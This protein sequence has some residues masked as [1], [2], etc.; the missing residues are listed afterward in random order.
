MDIENENLIDLGRKVGLDDETLQH[1]IQMNSAIEQI[2]NQMF[3][4][5][6]QRNFDISHDVLLNEIVKTGVD[7]EYARQFMLDVYN[8][9]L[10][11]IIDDLRPS[12]NLSD[13]MKNKAYSEIEEHFVDRFDVFDISGVVVTNFCKACFDVFL[14]S[15]NVFLNYQ[16]NTKQTNSDVS[17]EQRVQDL[18]QLLERLDD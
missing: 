10:K 4:T 7:S 8:T 9:G 2:Y 3:N 18:L 13:S 5:E 12:S 17:D 11:N 15:R 1:F 6:N 14:E 16:K